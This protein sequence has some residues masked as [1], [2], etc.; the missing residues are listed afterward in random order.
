M[1]NYVLKIYDGWIIFLWG[2]EGTCYK[3]DR[4]ECNALDA[5]DEVFE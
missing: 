3:F 2:N 4:D 5:C 1:I